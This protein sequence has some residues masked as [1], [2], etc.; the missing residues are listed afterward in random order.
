[1]TAHDDRFAEFMAVM[2]PTR[3]PE[4]A[5]DSTAPQSQV[6]P[7]PPATQSI[8]DDSTSA[9]EGQVNRAPSRSQGEVAAPAAPA[10]DG[11][12]ANEA[13]SDADYL[14]RRMK[15]RLDDVEGDED[16][17]GVAETVQRDPL[18]VQEDGEGGPASGRAPLAEALSPPDEASHPSWRSHPG[19]D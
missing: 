6:A 16:G 8:T 14:A 10:D 5:P 12:A 4:L 9:H 11:A 18:W 15:R 2:A 3:G 13:L 19:F 7:L 1:M 17:E